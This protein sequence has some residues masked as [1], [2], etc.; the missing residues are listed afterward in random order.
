MAFGSTPWTQSPDTFRHSAAA[1]SR[2]AS[3]RKYLASSDADSIAYTRSSHADRLVAKPFCRESAKRD[4]K[5][6]HDELR[7][8][9]WRLGLCRSH[10]FQGR[11]LLEGLHD[12]DEYVQIEGNDSANHVDP[13]PR[14][15]EVKR[16]SREDGNHQRHE[17]YDADPM[18][19]QKV[20]DR[21]EESGLAR[22]HRGRQQE[23]SPAVEPFPGEQPDHDDE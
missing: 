19:R 18:R 20:V 23:R 7:D 22:R 3:P 16:I 15:G 6:H 4:A 10:R 5:R 8:Q 2:G 9:E 17:R 1:S 21:K 13:A 11:H 12:R 14:A